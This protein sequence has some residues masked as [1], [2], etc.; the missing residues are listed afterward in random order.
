[1]TGPEPAQLGSPHAHAVFTYPKVRERHGQ[2]PPKTHLP[3]TAKDTG[4]GA[5]TTRC[6]R[7]LD[8]VPLVPHGERPTCPG[9]IDP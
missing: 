5:P 9:C 1:M 8:S 6:G 7:P 4:P 3:E 2:A